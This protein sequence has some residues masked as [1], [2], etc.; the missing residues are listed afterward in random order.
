MTDNEIKTAGQPSEKPVQQAAPQT[1]K[2]EEK[3]EEHRLVVVSSPHFSTSQTTPIIMRDVIIALIPAIAAGIY[4]FGLPA[5]KVLFLSTIFCIAWEAVFIKLF[6]KPGNI[7]DYLLDFSAIVTG[8]LLGLNLSSSA[9]WWMILIGSFIA[10]LLGKHVYGG[11]GQNPF[12]PA[13]VARV[14]LLV[15]FPVQMTTWPAPTPGQFSSVDA[16]TAATPLGILKTDGLQAALNSVSWQNLFFGNVGGCIG[17]VSVIALLIGGLYL[18]LRNVIRWEIPLA[19]IGIVAVISFI[20]AEV[21]PEKN[22]PM[23]FH[24]LSGGLLLGAFFMATDYV[25]S[26]ESSKGMLIFGAG[27]G[28]FTIIIRLFGGY[29]EGVSFA[30][31]IMNSLVPMIDRHI[32]PKRF[33]ADT[34]LQNQ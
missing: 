34:V 15:A 29:P 7:S 33:G 30:I 27:C 24:L 25:T 3:K 9:P 2:Q 5:L 8:V 26:P 12:N 19:F 32:V 14:F 1:D 10:M 17:E 20:F 23:F 31:L 18:L 16:V 28:F 22:A 11:L 4:I 6:K 13:L 21:N